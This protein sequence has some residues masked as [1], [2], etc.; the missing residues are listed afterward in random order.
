MSRHVGQAADLQR[1]TAAQY[2]RFIATV[3]QKAGLSWD[4]AEQAAGATLATLAER[5]SPGEARDVA[6]Q[7]P[8][9]LRGWLATDRPAESFHL[10]EFIRR[11]AMREGGRNLQEVERHVRAVFFALTQE[12]SDDELAD[13]AAEL[14]KDFAP[15]LS[16]VEPPP[17]P[18]RMPVEEFLARVAAR[19]GLDENGA[20]RATD[21][22]LETLAERISGGEVDDLGELLAPELR[23]ALERGKRSSGG[24]ARRISLQE[25]VRR[26]AEREGA[27]PEEAR[28]HARGVFAT[29]RE[30]VTDTEFADMTAQ[31]RDEYAAILARP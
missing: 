22:V 9:E 26:V 7:L 18:A 29:L 13:M 14:P 8:V 16:G 1:G 21:A 11:V 15:L 27:T 25:F 23:P 24:I 10:D 4:A 31:L 20:R 2:E 30:A 3:A 17:P 19:T 6:Q 5:L 12:L 28:E